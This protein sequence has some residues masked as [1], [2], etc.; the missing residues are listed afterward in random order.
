MDKVFTVA[1]KSRL[2]MRPAHAFLDVARAKS[3]NDMLGYNYN[4]IY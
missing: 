3:V 4:L 2:S 1:G